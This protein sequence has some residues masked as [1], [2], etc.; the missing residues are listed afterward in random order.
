MSDFTQHQAPLA[1]GHGPTVP[2]DE[3]E[4]GARIRRVRRP[5]VER[6]YFVLRPVPWRQRTPGAFGAT[7]A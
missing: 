5:W 2:S 7:A 1:Q 4:R 3:P 6:R